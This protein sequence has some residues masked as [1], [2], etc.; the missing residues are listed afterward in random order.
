MRVIRKGTTP[1]VQIIVHQVIIW[2]ELFPSFFSQVQ[3]LAI[4]EITADCE[5]LVLEFDGLVT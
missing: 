1:A 2:L 5:D 3:F 4:V